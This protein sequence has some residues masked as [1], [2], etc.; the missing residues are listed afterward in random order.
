MNESN[1]TSKTGTDLP[2]TTH[3]TKRIGR[4]ITEVD[5]GLDTSSELIEEELRSALRDGD[6]HLDIEIFEIKSVLVEDADT[7]D[8]WTI[9][10][11]ER[12]EFDPV[13]YTLVVDKVVGGLEIVHNVIVI[14][15]D[16]NDDSER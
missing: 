8:R 10:E 14:E 16:G 3:S 11:V 15:E 2:T 5:Y 7:G 6:L 1:Q 4:A 9:D 12:F 13:A